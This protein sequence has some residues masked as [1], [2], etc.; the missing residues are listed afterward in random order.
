MAEKIT[1]E[2]IELLKTRIGD[3]EFDYLNKDLFQKFLDGELVD[4]PR[5]NLEEL[6][7][8]PKMIMVSESFKQK[9]LL[10]QKPSIVINFRPVVKFCD[11]GI[12]EDNTSILERLS[13][14]ENPLI[15]I[16]QLYKVINEHPFP[17]KFTTE[18]VKSRWMFNMDGNDNIFFMKGKDKAIFCIVLRFNKNLRKWYLSSE[19]IFDKGHSSSTRVFKG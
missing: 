8:S 10:Y 12:F 3:P 15:T 6:Y 13:R 16:D 2:Q 5:M 9:I 18:N 17:K 7:F 19:E 1:D 4:P 14:C 11:L